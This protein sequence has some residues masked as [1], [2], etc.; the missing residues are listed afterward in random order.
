MWAAPERDETHGVGQTGPRTAGRKGSTQSARHL[1]RLGLELLR[2]RAM[3]KGIAAL[4]SR[5][6]HCMDPA[7]ATRLAFVDRIGSRWR[8]L[9]VAAVVFLVGAPAM[10]ADPLQLSSL[11]PSAGGRVAADGAAGS[12]AGAYAQ[13][14]ARLINEYRSIKGLGSLELV[15]DLTGLASEH[16][17]QMAEERRLSHDGFRDRF[18][19][20]RARICV[21]NVGVNFPHAEAQL[22]GWRASAGHHRNLLE[23]KVARMGIAISH[24]F[25]TF[26]ACS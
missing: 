14:L 5:A 12:R 1:A 15:S 25:V 26:F 20:T 7:S 8:L 2:G 4:A 3:M 13:H 19:R 22:D 24:S 17:L 18:D 11:T 23:P 16:A 21:E 9:A 6:I 10:A